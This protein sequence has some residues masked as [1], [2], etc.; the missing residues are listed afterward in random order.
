MT[1]LPLGF[2]RELVG[3]GSL[4]HD[5]GHMLG[6][7]A[8]WADQQLFRVD[9]GFL[10]AMLPPGAFIAFGIAARGSQLADAL[11]SSSQLM[12]RKK[13]LRDLRTTAA[14][15]P[16]PTTELEYSTPFE[17]LVAVILSAQATDKSVNLATRTLF[18]HANTPQA[19]LAL[20]VE[21]L[22]RIHPHHRP[23]QLE[24]EEHHRDVPTADRTAR[25]RS[26]RIA[27]GARSTARRRAQDGERDPEHR[28]RSADDGG[29]HAHLPRRES[30]GHRARQGRSRGRGQTAQGR[31]GGV[32]ST[33]RITG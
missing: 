1:L 6:D 29:R 2:A 7:W 20:G 32:R 18:K 31:A 28:V 26:A 5:A 8:G 17:L 13:D 16:N 14:A 24:G 21:G 33:T 27:R 4:L 9:M 19:I 22:S 30:H 10:L 11:R 15:N 12:N 25:R 23:V 3:R